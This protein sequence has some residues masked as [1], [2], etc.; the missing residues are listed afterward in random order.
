MMEEEEEEEEAGVFV[1]G[2]K[3]RTGNPTTTGRGNAGSKHPA[4]K[5][6]RRSTSRRERSKS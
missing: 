5:P 4:E 1:R 2:S 6:T 3:G